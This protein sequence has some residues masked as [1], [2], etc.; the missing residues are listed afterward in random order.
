[1]F[2]SSLTAQLV[3][4]FFLI[5]LNAFFA[6]SEMAIVSV[7][8]KIIRVKA[9]QGDQRAKMLLKILKEPSRFLSTIQ[10]GI[11]FAG[12]FSSASAAVGISE[13]LGRVLTNM[14]IPFGKN[15]AFIGVTL[16]LSYLMLVLGELVPKR[17]AL[18]DA[19]KFSMFAIKPINA[20]AKAMKPFI[21]FLSFSTNTILRVF[22][23]NQKGI[24]EKVTLEEIKSLVEVGHEQGVIN[25]VEREIIASAITF[26]E[27]VA[28]QIMTDRTEVDMINIDDSKDIN[29]EK[30]LKLKHSRVPVY[31]KYRDNIIGILYLKDYLLEVHR[32][33]FENVDI[34][35]V[36]RKP[37]FVPEYKNINDLFLELQRTRNH[38]SVLIDEYG[39]FSGI[40]TME[41]I[42]EEIVGEIE[43]EYDWDNPSIE[44]VDENTFYARGSTT[45]KD[46]NDRLDLKLE[47]DLG[48][49]DSLGGL[50]IHLLGYIPKQGQK[51]TVR[52]KNIRFEIKKIRKR[53][54]EYVKISLLEDENKKE[55]INLM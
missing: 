2:T 5:L 3:L 38:F 11:T 41:D 32:L 54:I 24:E 48:D 21:S 15:L 26:D 50:L 55:Q 16:L 37:Y 29:L 28:K 45:I 18:Q 6:A 43:D 51:S 8:K 44:I 7:N 53:K 47:T 39:G 40:V 49:Y 13:D 1:M 4:I 33:G 25:P 34:T 17:I 14:G 52:Y 12:F 22:G 19:E 9:R 46:L 31:K 20:F 27:K 30:M 23:F 10:V 35:K 36:M 42:I